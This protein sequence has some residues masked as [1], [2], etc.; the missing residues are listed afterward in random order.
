MEYYKCLGILPKQYED[1]ELELLIKVLEK[2]YFYKS[3][4]TYSLADIDMISEHFNIK[5][6]ECFLWVEKTI[7]YKL[8]ACINL[9]RFKSCKK[10]NPLALNRLKEIGFIYGSVLFET[11][12]EFGYKNVYDKI[13]S[14]YNLH[15]GD[16]FTHYDFAGN[17]YE[18]IKD[19]IEI[20]IGCVFR[21]IR[22]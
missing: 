15:L 12:Q 3:N 14:E 1:E 7:Q 20:K 4:K 11:P 22:D 2:L 18:I 10:N 8:H 5:C 6:F 19:S 16:D 9:L 21:K 17:Y 13:K